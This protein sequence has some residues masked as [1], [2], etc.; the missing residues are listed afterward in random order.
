VP[1]SNTL[2]TTKQAAQAAVGAM[3]C[4]EGMTR[5]TWASVHL[6]L[7]VIAQS[8]PKAFPSQRRISERTGIPLRSVQRYIAAAVKA[9][10][11][12]VEADAG[13][14]AKSTNGSRTNRYW[15]KLASS[16]EA[17]LDAKEVMYSYG[18]HSGT[19]SQEP[20]A[21]G[22][23]QARPAASPDPSG[24]EDL[25]AEGSTVVLMRRYEEPERDV[26]PAD[27]PP[28][29]SKHPVR[30]TPPTA[31][32]AIGE[33]DSGRRAEVH[34]LHGPA[35]T[36]ERRLSNFFKGCW[37]QMCM[38]QPEFREIRCLETH[39]EAKT[40][41]KTHLDTFSELEVRQMMREFIIAVSKRDITI[42]PGQSAWKRFTGA[43]GRQRRVTTGD[44]YAAYRD[45]ETG[46]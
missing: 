46:Q 12:V 40:Y 18:V 16:D 1:E 6:V 38:E 31:K 20:S 41:I 3:T 7:E 9:G 5:V 24:E 4:P 39:A 23:R 2:A 35:K 34:D 36:P 8:Y 42:K 28:G 22:T 15:V 45:K 21:P 26:T 30:P 32:E 10:L 19:S 17:N 43:W 33:T 29:P 11:L 13:A 25:A 14:Q 27:E 37:E 44:P